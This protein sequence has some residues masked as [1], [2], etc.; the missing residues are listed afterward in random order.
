MHWNFN[1]LKQYA[2]VSME[3]EEHSQR[4]LLKQLESNDAFV[5]VRHELQLT[6][7]LLGRIKVQVVSSTPQAKQVSLDYKDFNFTGA[8]C[9]TGS[10][11][12]GQGSAAK[13]YK[14]KV[15]GIQCAKKVQTAITADQLQGLV[16]QAS[17]LALLS[18]PHVMKLLGFYGYKRTNEDI[19]EGHWLMECMDGDLLDNSRQFR[20]RYSTSVDILLKLAKGVRYLDENGMAHRDLKCGNILVSK[21]PISSKVS[22]S[23]HKD[24]FQ[25]KVTDFDQSKFITSNCP[26][27]QVQSKPNV[28]SSPW[29]APEAFTERGKSSMHL[30]NPKSADSYSFAMTC[31]ELLSGEDPFSAMPGISWTKAKE[32][33]V[34]GRRPSLPEDCPVLLRE[35]I[36]ECWRTD[37]MLRPTFPEICRR[38]HISDTRNI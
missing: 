5:P 36:V 22:T 34:A 6:N 18:H 33:L 16:K 11:L 14:T 26:D 32:A 19:Y 2:L 35:L 7:Y 13:V 29:R 10:V 4:E 28:G 37:T 21:S 27:L 8:N 24:Y 1:R 12:L 20:N 23:T 17:M 25:I 9:F 38:L 31:F 30:V 3:C 15:L